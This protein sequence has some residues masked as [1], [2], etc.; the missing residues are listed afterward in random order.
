MDIR[1]VNASNGWQWITQGFSLFKKNPAIWIALFFIYLLIG[2]A[3]T[4]IPVIG[5]L[6][7]YL[8]APV[9]MAGY[10]IGCK[11]LENDE[12]LEIQHLFAGFKHNTSQLIS[13]GGLYIVGIIL[14][15]G[16]AVLL[17]GGSALGQMSNMHALGRHPAASEGMLLTA[18]ILLVG[19]L[20]LIMAYWFAPPLVVFQ[21]MK[22]TDAMKASF[23]AC[24][25]NIWPFTVYS[26]ISMVLLVVAAIPL[27]LGLLVMI[28]T[29]TASLYVSYKDIFGIDDV[30]ADAEPDKGFS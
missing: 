1:V 21:D 8:L 5:A 18:L 23:S 16:V 17:A 2:M 24:L 19:I 20:P 22:A 9:F 7:L 25:R 27:G 10:M 15:V 4:V 6:I 12:E 14:I 29:M 28:P 11:A 30:S 3:L 26:L 13:V